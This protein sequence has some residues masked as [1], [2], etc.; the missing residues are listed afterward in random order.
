MSNDSGYPVIRDE[1]PE[2]DDKKIWE[3]P[4]V[5][6]LEAILTEQVTEFDCP[7]PGCTGGLSVEMATDD[8]DARREHFI[9]LLEGSDGTLRC[10]DCS[11]P[12]YGL[13][14]DGDH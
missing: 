5:A 4:D 12:F 9:E 13:R 7:Y 14:G 6:P 1:P 3:N 11:E 8:M 10:E 2:D